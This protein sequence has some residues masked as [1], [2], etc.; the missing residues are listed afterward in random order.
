MRQKIKIYK[1][2]WYS[3]IHNKQMES[4][5][6]SRED[7]TATIDD[8]DYRTSFTFSG[9]SLGPSNLNFRQ[10]DVLSPEEF[11]KMCDGLSNQPTHLG[12]EMGDISIM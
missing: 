8:T 11:W 6:Y 9:T 4:L 1:L 2:S 5:Y 3:N 7:Y 10:I 12:P